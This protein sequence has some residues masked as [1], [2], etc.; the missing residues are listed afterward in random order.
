MKPL[1]RYAFMTGALLL[2]APAWP[3]E[4]PAV[5]APPQSDALPSFDML[6]IQVDGNTVLE[7]TVVEKTLYPLLGT[8]KT[9][10]DVEQARQ[11][12]E[13][14][15]KEKGYP[16]V[17]VD[18][19]E[20]D[21]VAGVVR[22]QVV[23]GAIERLKITG[24]RYFH[25]DKIREQVP[26]L[27][28]GQVPYMPKVQEQVGI[29]G[30]ESADRQITPIFR[31]GATPGKT[32]VELR[33]TDEL[34]LHGSVEVNGRNSENTSRTRMVSAVR[35]DN[36]WQRFHSASLQFQ[37]AP[38][39]DD[40]VEVWSGTYVLPTGWADT[41]LA[42]YGIGI[43]SNTQMGTSIGGL[44]VVGTGSIYG[45]RL[46]KPL[47]GGEIYNHSLTLGI[48]YK[49]FNQGVTQQGQD[50]QTSPVSYAPW[51]I[52]Y[53]GSWRAAGALTSFS[54]ALHFSVDG[55]GSDQQEFENRRFKARAGYAYLSGELKHWHELPW[56]M[57]LAARAA[58]Q[59]SASPLISNEQF[60]VGG[61]QSVRGYHQTQQL[62]DNGVNASLELQSPSFQP[63]DWDF[64]QNLKAH[65]FFDYAYLWIQD[66][67]PR[68][69]EH[70]RLAG[71][72]AG[73]RMQLFKHWQGEFD[74]AYPLYAQSSV[75]AG[76][77]RVDFRVAYE[78]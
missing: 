62:G 36:L 48:D 21:V 11:T 17:L 50:Q 38:E 68:N 22:L 33:V 25:L 3:Q 52:G 61:P 60:A 40:E 54:A 67:L 42:L 72:G 8:G 28:A 43:S 70:Y 32:E 76:E 37:V 66:A 77:Q 56:D 69:P 63:Q 9:V 73:L 64:L 26:A 75:A 35:Y 7:Q 20:Q 10:G 71:A 14:L 27:A 12:L 53:D 59:I 24:S 65:V 47:S 44:S 45:A 13:A 49:S 51:Q 5:A 18:I 19:P 39:N 30:Q 74:W 57:R 46:I 16:T 41:R 55:L 4:Q 29:L 34:P 15:Y 23:E 58:G 31:A 78:F 2:A 1:T 6:E